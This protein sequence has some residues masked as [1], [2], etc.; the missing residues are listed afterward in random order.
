MTLA[1]NLLLRLSGNKIFLSLL[2]GTLL[3]GACKPRVQILKPAEVE[4]PVSKEEEKAPI[5]NPT[6]KKRVFEIALLLPFQLDHVA[7]QAIGNEDIQRSALALDFYQGFQVGLETVVGSQ[8]LFNVHVLDSRD[9]VTHVRSLAS[10]P[11]IQAAHLIVGPVYPK[12]IL[13]FGQATAARK[14]IIISPLAASLPSEFNFPNLV[15][16]TSPITAHAKS[17]ANR[18]VQQYRSGDQVVLYNSQD[19]SSKQFLPQV[20]LAIQDL[21]AQIPI[22]EVDD[23]QGLNERARHAGK[24][25]VVVGTSNTYELSPLFSTFLSMKNRDGVDIRV[26]G[27]PNWAKIHFDASQQLELFQTSITSS[28]YVERTRSEVSQF[29]ENY[30]KAFQ[31]DPTEFAFKGYDAGRYFG[32]LIEKHGV[33]FA[34]HLLKEPYQGI[35]NSFVWEQH[36]RWGF[37]NQSAPVLHYKNGAF[38]PVN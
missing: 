28:F 25:L 5:S 3:F 23:E 26:F 18:I 38:V 30:K 34:S 6:N 37:V 15:T 36:S 4:K 16:V 27:H 35:H 33:D 24:N 13:A 21:N 32:R 7:P 29:I 8:S 1:P 22:I 31:V 14:P 2:L 17:L 9:D 19:A 12:E 20:R 10:K 11:E